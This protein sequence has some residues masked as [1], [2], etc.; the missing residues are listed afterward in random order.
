ME[1]LNGKLLSHWSKLF[2]ILI[3]IASWIVKMVTDVSIE[4]NDAIKVALFVALVFAPI[5]V[6]IWLKILATL[7]PRKTIPDDGKGDE[8]D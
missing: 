7:L 3:V 6:S 8:S 4:M 1:N 5:D 2:S